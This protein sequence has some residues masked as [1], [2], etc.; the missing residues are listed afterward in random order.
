[1]RLAAC[2]VLALL[3]AGCAG[4]KIRERPPRAQQ[5]IDLGQQGQAAY[6]KGDLPRAARL[7]GQG[8]TEAMRIEDSEGVGVMSINLA[9]ISREAGDSARALKILDTVSAWHRGNLVAKTRQE[10]DLLAAVLLSDL[11]RRDEAL[12]RLQALRE[13][14]AATCEI[15]IAIGIDSLQAR[16]LLEQGEAAASARL[17]QAAIE[18]FRSHGNPLEVANLFRVEGEAQLALGNY[19]AARQALESAL[20][21]DKSLGQPAKIAQ[22]LEALAR[23]ALAAKDAAAHAGYLARLEEVRR[24]RSSKTFR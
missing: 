24:A 17:A 8:L 19:P 18:R 6:F 5:V 9:R 1:M 15:A 4:E 13:Q 22:D 10:M 7:F 20:G 23:N 12:G 16:L 2:L 3:L 21:I 11:A 14:C